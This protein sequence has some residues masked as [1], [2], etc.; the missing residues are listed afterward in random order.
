MTYA[1]PP[2]MAPRKQGTNP[3]VWILVA[4]AAF[5]CVGIIAFGAMTFAVMG[6]VK[7]LTPCIFTLDTLDRSLKDYVADKGAYPSADKW[8]D[9]LAPYYDKHYK[10]HVKEMQDVPGPMKGFAEMADI[11]A[12]LSCNSKTSPKTFIA[13]NPDVAGKKRTDFTDPSKVIVFFETTSTGRNITEKF[14][15]RDFKDSPRMMGEPRGWYEMDLEGQMVVTDK[16]GKTK[17]VNI[18][19]NN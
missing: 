17:R 6:Q 1:A 14:V 4:F 13:F 19:T 12:E 5:C 15:A 2:G 8:Q 9:E 3:L 16:R 18:E 7:D 10:D 11:K